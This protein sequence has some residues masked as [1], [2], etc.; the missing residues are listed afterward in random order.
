MTLVDQLGDRFGVEPIL[1]V[2]EVPVSTFYGWAARRRRPSPREVEEVWL[3]EQ[4]QRIHKD[5]GETYGSP[6]VHAQLRREGICVSRKRVE[7]LLRQAGL[8]GAFMRKRK[9]STTRRENASRTLASHRAPSPVGIREISATH[10]RSGA[11][12]LK[13]RLTRSGAGVALGS[14]RVE[15]RLRLRMNAPAGPLGASAAPPAYD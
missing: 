12:V 8:K 14:R 3:G 9:R 10:S 2:L 13:L 6:K 15:D 4:I 11:S 7:R 5:S 1:R